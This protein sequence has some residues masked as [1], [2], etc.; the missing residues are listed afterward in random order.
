MESAALVRALIAVLLGS[1]AIAKALRFG[2]F[3][4]AFSD[5]ELVPRRAVVPVA[6]LVVVAEAACSSALVAG[7]GVRVALAGG[8]VL[9]AAFAIAVALTLRRSEPIA[10]GCLGDMVALRMDWPA[11]AMNAGLAVAALA[12]ATGPVAALPLPADGQQA[13]DLPFVAWA[14]ATVGVV[15][16]WLLIYARTVLHNVEVQLE[17]GRT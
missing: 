14:G 12:A 11:V 4:A 16:Y 7:V 8:A 5:Y 9:L 13:A 15:T 1:A 3:T 6:V 10:C 17:E 2:G